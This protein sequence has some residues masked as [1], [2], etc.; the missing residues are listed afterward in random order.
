MWSKIYPYLYERTIFWDIYL[1]QRLGVGFVSST[2]EL[3]R[4]IAKSY[5][6][7]KNKIIQQSRSTPI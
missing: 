6:S 1:F 4:N 5:E 2:P 3:S 7:A